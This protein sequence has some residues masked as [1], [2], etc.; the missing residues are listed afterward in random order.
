MGFSRPIVTWGLL[1]LWGPCLSCA[2]NNEAA[3]RE[4]TEA[5]SDSGL[6]DET[7]NLPETC[8]GAVSG[9]VRRNGRDPMDAV[10][11]VCIGLACFKGVSTDAEGRFRCVPELEKGDVCGRYDFE[12]DRLHIEIAA[13]ADPEAYA[14]YA[15]V[16][17]PTQE[18]ISDLGDDDFDY[19]VGDL[20]LYEL[21]AESAVYTPAGGASV[22]L[23]G[24]AFELAP[25][26]LVKAAVSEDVPIAHDQEIRVFEA[27]LDEWTP[28]FVDVELD[29][30]YLITPRWAKLSGDGV[31]L[32]IDPP[33]SWQEGDTGEL[34]LLGGF[35]SEWG[36]PDVISKG[37]HIY[38]AED[39]SAC[40]ASGE[41]L[42]TVEDGVLAGCG[43]AEVTGD[44]IVTAPIPRFTWVGIGR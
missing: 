5:D 35:V 32:A 31:V 29:A 37:E 18:E 36:D 43:S 13:A 2:G 33:S 25:G 20:S 38:L 39:H 1:L 8:L 19:A 21:P 17:H 14:S 10:V 15:F 22:N 44:R 26:A 11:V 23:S 30:L 12:K 42:E 9:R 3:S 7:S 24:V 28:P 27:P 40:L 41:G 16:R 4:S 6:G 34:Y